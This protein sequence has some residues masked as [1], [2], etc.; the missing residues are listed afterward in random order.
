M[1]AEQ[2]LA[3]GVPPEY[4]GYANGVPGLPPFD[5]SS[6][7]LVGSKR[8]SNGRDDASKSKWT[9]KAGHGGGGKGGAKGSGGTS[10]G[11]DGSSELEC[12]E[13][14]GA[15]RGAARGDSS[16]GLSAAARKKAAAADAKFIEWVRARARRAWVWSV[17]RAAQAKAAARTLACTPERADTLPETQAMRYVR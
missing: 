4:A 11:D 9:R 12:D 13:S 2:S 1:G 3:N 6:E 7:P 14:A 8:R 16:D 10:T 15:S 5:P 17:G